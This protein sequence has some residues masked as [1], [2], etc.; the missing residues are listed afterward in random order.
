[1]GLLRCWCLVG[2]DVGSG[3]ADWVTLVKVLGWL[4]CWVDLRCWLGSVVVLRWAGWVEV[5]GLVG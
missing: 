2:R 3:W 5:L 1:M 4:R